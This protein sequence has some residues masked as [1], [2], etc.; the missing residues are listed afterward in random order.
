MKTET[1]EASKVKETQETNDTKKTSKVRDTEEDKKIYNTNAF[2]TY[3][4]SSLTNQEKQIESEWTKT[5]KFQETVYSIK[6]KRNANYLFMD[7]SDLESI[8]IYLGNI[9]FKENNTIFNPSN[10][11]QLLEYINNN[12]K[13]KLFQ[14]GT[15]NLNKTEILDI[16]EKG[17]GNTIEVKYSPFL[18][19]L[20]ED[21]FKEKNQTKNLEDLTLEDLSLFY[22]EYF[23]IIENNIQDFKFIDSDERKNFMDSIL[24]KIR[25]EYIS[26][27][28]LYGPFGIG[29][30]T[31]LMAYQKKLKIKSAYFN[32]SAIFHLKDKSKYIKMI[33]YESMS[34]F[35]NYQQFES[36]KKIIEI[37]DYDSPWDIIK[38][39]INFVSENIKQTFLIILDQYKE[40]YEDFKFKSSE[41][42]DSLILNDDTFLRIIKCSSMNDKDVK[43][44]FLNILD[45]NNYIYIGKLFQIDGLEEREKLY[46][47]NVSLFHYLYLKYEKD[48]EDFIEYEKTEIKSDIKK[49][50]PNSTNLLK[51]ISNITNIMK[52][53]KLFDE[54][55][56]KA[57]LVTIPL[58]YILINKI[59]EDGKIFYTFDYPCLLI[60]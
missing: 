51:V 50:I 16:C 19:D 36:L 22:S 41:K 46:F 57:I 14:L 56:I 8:K 2:N 17:K 42:I 28:E 6:K 11:S 58:K 35:E 33:L 44:N 7:I 59:E 15:K 40:Q 38:K 24:K 47:G 3:I 25:R 12:R 53:N 31:T 37:M 49:S 39:V 43:N 20:N 18:R 45:K 4:V 1:G 55:E 10:S 34:L 48:F 27:I 52:S 26:P 9:N 29:K 13:T 5:I 30:S 21:I 23:P 54:H 60:I 32:L